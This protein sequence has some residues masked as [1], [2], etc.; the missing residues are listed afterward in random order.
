MRTKLFLLFILSHCLTFAQSDIKKPH[1][2]FDLGIRF[3][4]SLLPDVDDQI[5][6]NYK[7]GMNGA[8]NVSYKLNKYLRL[9]AEVSFAQKGKS[10]NYS[11]TISLFTNFNELINTIVDTSLISLLRG[12][13]N[14]NVYSSYNGYHKLGYLEMPLLLEA[15]YYKFKF[16]AGPYIGLTIK[17]YTKEYLNQ[18]IP[19]IDLISPAIDSLGTSAFLINSSINSIFPG[20]NQTSITESTNTD[21]FTVWNVGY[22]LQIGYQ[23]HANTFLEASYSKAFNNYLIDNTNNYRLAAFTLSL[24]YNFELNKLKN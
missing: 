17:S 12:F 22:I 8:V 21:Q 6:K 24:R 15:T 20:Y 4:G 11:D 2:K 16:S 9:K 5:Q 7:L 23:I 14:D 10:Y 1:T 18:E 3:G 13:V 19:L